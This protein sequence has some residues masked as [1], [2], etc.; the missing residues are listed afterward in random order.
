MVG[1]E[2]QIPLSLYIYTKQY[3]NQ[4]MST[5]TSITNKKLFFGTRFKKLIQT[6]PI[7]V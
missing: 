3:Q 4:G 7:A 1:K 5:D 2:V 6:R